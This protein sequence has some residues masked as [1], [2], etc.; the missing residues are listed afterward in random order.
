MSTPKVFAEGTL[1]IVIGS[2]T[3]PPSISVY[4]GPHEI[5]MLKALKFKVG[6]QDITKDDI[7]NGEAILPAQTEKE[8][9]NLQ[10]EQEARMLSPFKWMT[11]LRK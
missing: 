7:A 1:T 4:A 11:I 2:E 9:V 6:I 10:I 3:W 8:D 5:R